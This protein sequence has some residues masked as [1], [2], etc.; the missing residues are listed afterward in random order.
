MLGKIIK[1]IIYICILLFFVS[2]I[3]VYGKYVLEANQEMLQIKHADNEKPSINGRNYDVNYENFNRDVNVKFSDNLGIKSAKYWFNQT[4]KVFNDQNVA[5]LENN[6]TFSMSGWYKVEVTDLYN[7]KTIY[8]FL[9]DKEFNNISVNATSANDVSSKI[10]INAQD[11]LTGVQKIEIFIQGKLY[12]TYTYG[13]WF[14]KSKTENLEIKIVDL[15]F[16][17]EMYVVGTDFYGNSKISNK[18]IPNTT[19]IY[20]VE[21][22]VKF[23]TLVNGGNGFKGVT[24]YLLN[25][26]DLS[27]VCSKSNSW[28]PI[29]IGVGF[30][31]IFEGNNH[32]ISNLY[33][34]STSDYQGLFRKISGT[35]RNFS[36]SRKN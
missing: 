16:Y 7:N 35:L 18:V 14:V 19:R 34:N 15:P 32:T 22:F 20:D 23:R 13:E 27:S 26:L 31:G 29:G 8:I 10:T 33:I 24:L 17:E 21:D 3:S 4:E 5:N 28:I 25:N 11:N 30:Q 9:I 1:K 6:T 2:F 12:K 36:L